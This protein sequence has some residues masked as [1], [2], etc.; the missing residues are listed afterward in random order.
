MLKDLPGNA[1]G[2]GRGFLRFP[3]IERPFPGN[4]ARRRERRAHN[5]GVG[6][7]AEVG[8]TVAADATVAAS[9]TTTAGT[10]AV[11]GANPAAAAPRWPA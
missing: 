3:P 1:T 7:A 10:T 11:A 2:S 4:V 6:V 9:A 5:R 8:L